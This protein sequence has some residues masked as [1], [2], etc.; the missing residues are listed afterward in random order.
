MT[1]LT[2][3]VQA[4]DLQVDRLSAPYRKRLVLAGDSFAEWL[5]ARGQCPS[6][7][8][9]SSKSAIDALMAFVQHCYE[10]GGA[11][12]LATHAVLAVQTSNRSLHGRLRPAWDSIQAWKL[13]TPVHSRVPMPR[14]ILEALRIFAVLAAVELDRGQSQAWWRFAA[15]L[16]AGFWG[17]LRPKELKG[18]FRK[19]VRVPG[20]ASLTIVDPQNRAYMGRLQARTVR[21]GFSV[22][23]LQWLVADCSSETALWGRGSDLFGKLLGTALA[24]LGLQNLGIT[25]ASLRAGGAT[26]LLETGVPV[27]NLR[28]QGAWASERSMSSYLQEAEA[29]ATMLDMS[30]A[31]SQ[32]VRW[33]LLR[34]SR[35]REPPSIALK[36]LAPWTPEP[37]WKA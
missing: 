4:G 14:I 33:I 30:V 20:P 28:F 11:L 36:L 8:L 10:T 5:V 6:A 22:R 2:A 18:L 31:S 12:W 3:G 15:L 34:Y 24:A 23:W 7:V 9:S 13:Q 29:A 16:G 35:C 26:H 21:D 17:L 19:H 32:T 37:S 25:P 27:A 1:K